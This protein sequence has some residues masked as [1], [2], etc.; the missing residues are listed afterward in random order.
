MKPTI[1]CVDLIKHFEGC[2]LQAYQ[3]PAMIWTIGYGTTEYENGAKVK[4]GDQINQYRADEL[5]L[6]GLT[7]FANR[8]ST[9]YKREFTENQNDAF[10]SMAYNI[11]SGAF[12]GSMLL[13]TANINPDDP[14]IRALFFRYVKVKGKILPGLVRRRMSEHW[15][16]STG[17]IKTEWTLSEVEKAINEFVFPK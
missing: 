15:L 14:A 2:K 1:K 4:Q 9:S 10:V 12:A 5:L 16:Y 11:G 17:E 3:C 13:S 7:K 6:H 8:I